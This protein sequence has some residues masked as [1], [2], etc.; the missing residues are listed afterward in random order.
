MTP[1]PLNS[2]KFEP[3]SSKTE[4]S[5]TSQIQ[6]MT[7]TPL[8]STKFE[9]EHSSIDQISTSLLS[10]FKSYSNDYYSLKSIFS[11]STTT[12]SSSFNDSQNLCDS[13][14]LIMNLS[15]TSYPYIKMYDSNNPIIVPCS[16]SDFQFDFDIDSDSDIFVAFTDMGGF[17]SASGYSESYFGF[18]SGNYYINRVSVPRN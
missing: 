9:P 14:S 7:S 11:S 6:I 4:P 18:S 5:S 12:L 3:E 1:T 15:V 8:E 13:S 16:R 17:S 2:S 10:V